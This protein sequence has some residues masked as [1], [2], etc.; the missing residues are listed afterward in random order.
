MKPYNST[1]WTESTTT[2]FLISSN[3][4]NIYKLVCV[5]PSNRCVSRFIMCTVMQYAKSRRKFANLSASLFIVHQDQYIGSIRNEKN[6]YNLNSKWQQLRY[7][8]TL[9]PFSTSTIQVEIITADRTFLKNK[10]NMNFKN[11]FTITMI[12]SLMSLTSAGP[13]AAGICYAG[14]ILI[15]FSPFFII[16]NWVNSAIHIGCAAVTVAC[17]AAAGFTFGTVPGLLKKNSKDYDL[18]YNN[19]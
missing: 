13:V 8:F 1:D 5:Q 17:F 4:V 14:N 2:S 11:L 6:E 19:I 10:K 12:F 3:Y 18:F 9:V 16:S 15:E 7:P